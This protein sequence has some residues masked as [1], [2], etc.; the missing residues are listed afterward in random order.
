MRGFY[1]DRPWNML[2]TNG[3]DTLRECIDGSDA[4]LATLD[5]YK[6]N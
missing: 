2:G 6:N 3:W 5:R 4:I 1:L